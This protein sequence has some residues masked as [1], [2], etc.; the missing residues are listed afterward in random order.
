MYFNC[1]SIVHFYVI[2]L[3][4]YQ[5]YERMINVYFSRASGNLNRGMLIASWDVGRSRI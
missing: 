2:G 1:T 4:L 5:L 3:Y